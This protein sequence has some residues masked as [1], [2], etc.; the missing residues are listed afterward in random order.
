[1][2]LSEESDWL[3]AI[4]AAVNGELELAKVCLE[5]LIS[6]A[7]KTNDSNRL[8]YIYQTLGDIEARLGNIDRASTLH[9]Q[10]IALD[11]HSPLPYL[12]YAQGLWKAFNNTS[13]SLA[14]IEKAHEVLSNPRWTET[15]NELPRSWYLEEFEILRKEVLSNE[16]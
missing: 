16:R 13:S 4:P 15:D 12:F 8:G 3:T 7:H 9:E 10:A 14:M 6:K 1:M 11:P 5:R 2:L